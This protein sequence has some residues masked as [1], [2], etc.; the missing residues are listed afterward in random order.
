VFKIGFIDSIG[1]LGIAYY[2]F[3][4]GKEAFKKASGKRCECCRKK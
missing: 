4:E 2:A 3:K 1:A